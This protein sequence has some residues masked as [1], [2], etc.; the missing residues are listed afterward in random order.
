MRL[1]GQDLLFSW[2]LKDTVSIFHDLNNRL[3]RCIQASIQCRYNQNKFSAV[4][5]SVDL[6]QTKG[7]AHGR[8]VE[9]LEFMGP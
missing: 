4:Y 6:V 2:T 9:A 7:L 8:V 3:E 1:S 5:A